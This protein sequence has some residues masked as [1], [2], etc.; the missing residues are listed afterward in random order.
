VNEL[1]THA[2]PQSDESVERALRRTCPVDGY[3]LAG[4]PPEHRCPEC[5]FRFDGSTRVWRV[6]HPWRVTVLPTMLLL[7]LL[8]GVT[9]NA[10]G[11]AVSFQG[12]DRSMLRLGVSG[13]VT[14]AWGWYA[15]RA[16]FMA[17]SG[18]F[19]AT[20][21][22]GIVMRLRDRAV[23]TFAWPRVAKVNTRWNGAHSAC[24][25]ELREPEESVDVGVLVRSRRDA[26]CFRRAVRMRA[27]ALHSPS[28]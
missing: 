13:A 22:D 2:L 21:P 27:Q 28:A 14:V 10:L 25:V 19:L 26:V 3:D 20:S 1:L 18:L 4:L 17:R 23:R 12:P 15:C 16:W 5:G 11:M 8:A 6:D 24:R 9:A 7:A